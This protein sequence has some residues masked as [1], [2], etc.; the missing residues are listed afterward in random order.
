MAIVRVDQH[1]E[2]ALTTALDAGASGIVIP[3]CETA[4][5]VRRM[6]QKINFREF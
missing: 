4:E 5:E 2:P 6:V 1:D 3:H